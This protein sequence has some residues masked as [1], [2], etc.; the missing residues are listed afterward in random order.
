MNEPTRLSVRLP[1][2]RV[3]LLEGLQA[4]ADSLGKHEVFLVPVITVM[5]G[6]CDFRSTRSSNRLSENLAAPELFAGE[7]DFNATRQPVP[8][9]ALD[10]LTVQV[11][12]RAEQLS[13]DEI[14]DDQGSDVTLTPARVLWRPLIRIVRR[15]H[16]PTLPD[17][18]L[19][20]VES[21]HSKNF[22]PDTLLTSGV[23]RKL[24]THCGARMLTT[25]SALLTGGGASPK[26]TSADGRSLHPMSARGHV[27][28]SSPRTRFQRRSRR[29]TRVRAARPA[30]PD[31]APLRKSGAN[32][33]V[34]EL[35]TERAPWR[36]AESACPSRPVVRPL[37]GRTSRAGPVHDRARADRPGDE[38]TPGA[39]T[40]G[41]RS[42]SGAG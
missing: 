24:S 19:D 31:R 18:L 33:V 13:T 36:R 7:V 9:M 30:V 15:I 22:N 5:I 11:H 21:R 26:R 37:P 32:R 27:R 39:A 28:A 2:R 40:E 1:R 17:C 25:A 35:P 29:R 16:A 12:G 42:S 23:H 3:P 10:S 14:V 6:R 34:P 8:H 41:V 38:P 20:L 4:S